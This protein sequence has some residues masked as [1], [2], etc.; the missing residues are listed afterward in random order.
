MA[1][2]KPQPERYTALVAEEYPPNL[3]YL[4]L[5]LEKLRLSH[6]SVRTGGYGDLFIPLRAGD[7]IQTRKAVSY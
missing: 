4:L 1:E 5:I 3:Q 6:Q 7:Y 2:E